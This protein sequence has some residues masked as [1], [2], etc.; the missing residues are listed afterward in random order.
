MKHGNGGVPLAEAYARYDFSDATTLFTDLGVTNVVVDGDL[1]RQVNDLSVNGYHL[2]APADV[3]RPKYKLNIQNGRSIVRFDAISQILF[4]LSNTALGSGAKTIIRVTKPL[5]V[6]AKESVV[7]GS[8]NAVGSKVHL[9]PEIIAYTRTSQK[10]FNETAL[11]TKFSVIEVHGDTSTASIE[12]TLDGVALTQS[13]LAS[14]ALN[15]TQGIV[16]GGT[17]VTAGGFAADARM[18]EAEVVFFDKFLTASE[19][20]N[21]LSYLNIK[22]GLV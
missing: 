22:W 16:I 15:T 14:A 1:I 7:I 12:G 20:S 8:D 21:W 11:T 3:N 19:L 18:D 2:T 13:S 10:V 9:S 17:I 6:S 4:T 5:V